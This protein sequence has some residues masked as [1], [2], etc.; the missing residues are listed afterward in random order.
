MHFE[1]K[2]G[3]KVRSN[4]LI[5]GLCLLLS[6]SMIDEI[7]AT[8]LLLGLKSDNG[9]VPA[10]FFA[11]ATF[12]AIL[13]GPVSSRWVIVAGRNLRG[14]LAGVL[15]FESVVIAWVC[16]IPSFPQIYS[17]FLAA[18]MLGLLGGIFWVIVLAYISQLFL[19]DQ[20]DLVNKWTTTVRNLGFV[21][22]PALGGLLFAVNRT[23]V[24]SWCILI[25]GF[26]SLLVLRFVVPCLVESHEESGTPESGLSPDRWLFF[27]TLK[28]LYSIPG[29]VSRL[30]PPMGVAFFGS[31]INVALVVYVLSV[32]GESESTYG[33]ISASISIGLVLGAFTVGAIAKKRVQVGIGISGI[34]VGAAIIGLMIPF[35]FIVQLAFGLLLGIGNGGQNSYVASMLMQIIPE[36][37]RA[38]LMPA[39]VFSIYSFVF[40]AF[41]V[42][43]VVDES[44][45]VLIMI[46]GGAFTVGLGVF[47]AT[48]MTIAEG[49]GRVN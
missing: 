39:F 9:L 36:N 37:R 5:F 29:I 43:F 1:L 46:F 40:A 20:Y 21:A 44:N 7:V 25:L 24:F 16:F 12:G 35:P 13:S 49:A 27:N 28:E 3:F 14:M 19:D 4:F 23:I 32:R 41:L 6:C 33:L 38:Q 42:G 48:R 31:L 11:S 22:G 34:C 45:V 15:M 8:L 18:L 2:N 10:L 26:M 47:S 17:S 30:L